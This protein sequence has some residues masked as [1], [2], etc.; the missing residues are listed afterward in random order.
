[1]LFK[2]LLKL[3]SSW[4]VAKGTKTRTYEDDGLGCQWLGCYDFLL[5]FLEVFLGLIRFSRAVPMSC[6][7]SRGACRFHC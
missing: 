7:V 1:M 5:M 4:S 6:N 3:G 2:Q